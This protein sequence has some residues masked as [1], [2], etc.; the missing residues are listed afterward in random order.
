MNRIN[1]NRNSKFSNVLLKRPP[2][3]PETVFFFCTWKNVFLAWKKLDFLPWKCV[4]VREKIFKSAREKPILYVKFSPNLHTWKYGAVYVKKMKRS[5]R[6]NC[7]PLREKKRKENCRILQQ[8]DTF[9][10]LSLQWY[11]F[12]LKSNPYVTALGNIDPAAR[13]EI[14]IF[15]VQNRLMYLRVY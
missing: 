4:P 11:N 5:F 9:A 8:R 15:D 12:Y 13:P 3:N 6:E 1:R 2:C 7:Q 10:V 14:K